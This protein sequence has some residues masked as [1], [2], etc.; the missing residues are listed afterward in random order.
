MS[1]D[2]SI[3]AK[4]PITGEWYRVTEWE[5]LEDGKVVAR[6]K[7][8]IDESEVPEPVREQL[9]GEEESTSSD[10]KIDKVLE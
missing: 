3:I 10:Y 9:E 1:V 4:S 5:T 8:P 2:E 7:E 6:E